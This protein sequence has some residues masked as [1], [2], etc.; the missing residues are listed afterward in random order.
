MKEHRRALTFLFA[1][2]LIDMIGFG[3]V[4]PVLPQLIMHLGQIPIDKAALWAGWLGAG[5]AAMQFIFAPIL[6]NLSDR[7][8]RR[9][10]L[11][12]AL[13]GFGIDYIVMGFAP[14]IWWLVIGRFFAGI[15]GA[16]FSAAY[17]YLADITPPEKRAQSFGTIGMAFGFGFILG[18]AI[19]GLLGEFG[20]RIPFYA[21]GAL[22]LANFVFGWFWLEES[23]PAEKRRPFR[24]ARA[25]AFSALRALSGQSPKV[26]WFVAALALWQLAHL[27]YPAVWAYFAIAAFG[28]T[29]WKIGLSLMMVGITSALVQGFG[30]RLLVPRLG[31]RGAVA[32]G[33]GS[34]CAAALIYSVAW[35]DWVVFVGIAVGGFQ[36]L[37]MPSINALNSRAVDASSQGELQGATQAVGSLAAIVGPPFYTILF[38]RFTGA[39]AIIPFPAMPL[40][41]SAIIAAAML[42]V[43]LYAA[44]TNARS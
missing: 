32:L 21:A 1:V 19:G 30:L 4:M 11:L 39:D 5:Y 13:L 24:L 14:N 41:A 17:A 29:E 10:V 23:L 15:T 34:V 38:A 44:R 18:P 27:V 7:F 31:E 36:G 25:N 9:P 37:I 16:S 33:V 43:F 20:P 26:L 35:A 6:G 12:A 42:C 28:W 22:A 2:V 40:V 3:I 8:G